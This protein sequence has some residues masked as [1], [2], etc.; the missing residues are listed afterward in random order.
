MVRCFQNV[1]LSLPTLEKLDLSNNQIKSIAGDIGSLKKLAFLS[2]ANNKI[3]KLP[4]GISKL[5]QLK[6]LS[7]NNNPL[8][9]DLAIAIGPSQNNAQ[10]QT[11]AVNAIQYLKD[12][13]GNSKNKGNCF[14]FILLLYF[15][16]IQ[17]LIFNFF[18]TTKIKRRIKKVAKP[19][20]MVFIMA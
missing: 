14:Q 1:F 15:Y 5:K 4:K 16:I 19:Q 9:S 13:K 6:H 2:L 3:K 18:Q 11:A 17:C 8:K 12:I 20:Q 7:V 10:C